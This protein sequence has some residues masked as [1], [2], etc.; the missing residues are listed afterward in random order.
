MNPMAAPLRYG[1][2]TALIS[3]S[4]NV[5]KNYKIWLLGST[6]LS[7]EGWCPFYVGSTKPF[8]PSR[9]NATKF[10]KKET[11]LLEIGCD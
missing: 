11:F 8:D 3:R 4:S 9:V 1:G 6:I 7:G 5:G 10:Q 2:T